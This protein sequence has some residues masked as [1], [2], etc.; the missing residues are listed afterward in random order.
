MRSILL[1]L[2][3]LIGWLAPARAQD[4]RTFCG[5][6]VGGWIEVL[7]DKTSLKS[8]RLRAVWALGAIGPE[9]KAAVPD[10]IDEVR[11]GQIKDEAVVALVSIGAGTEVTVPALIE[12]FLKAGCLHLTGMGTFGFDARVRDNLVRIGGPAV[13]ALL[14]I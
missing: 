10:L 14:D 9:A 5:K 8:D 12:Q 7:R 13:P 1:L 4:Q 3:V 2:L 11:Q 6:T